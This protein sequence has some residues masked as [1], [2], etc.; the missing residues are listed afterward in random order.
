[1][2]DITGK[3]ICIPQIT[4]ASALGAGIAASLGAGWFRTGKE[5]AAA[6]TGLKKII[7]PDKNNH[8][9]YQPLFAVYRNIYPALQK[10]GNIF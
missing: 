9:K 4:E 5:A 2:A 8:K 1:M 6:M 7:L 3:N 10:A